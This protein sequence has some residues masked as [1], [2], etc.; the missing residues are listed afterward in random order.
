MNKLLGGISVLDMIS[1]EYFY[2]EDYFEKEK[3]NFYDTDYLSADNAY[4]DVIRELYKILNYS[5]FA[6]AESTFNNY[7][8]ASER[9][10]FKTGFNLGLIL[11][12]ELRT[13]S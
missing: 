11:G 5:T 6:E 12:N 3:K 8:V 10:A 13:L 2:N 1:D 9:V 7:V 4:I